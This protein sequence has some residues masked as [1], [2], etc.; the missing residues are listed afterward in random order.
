ME[1]LVLPLQ[2]KW[3]DLRVVRMTTLPSVGDVNIG[4]PISTFVLNTLTLK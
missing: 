4:S 1:V 2:C 3:L